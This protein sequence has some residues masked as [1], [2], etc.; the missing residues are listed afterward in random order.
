[1]QMFLRHIQFINV[2]SGVLHQSSGWISGLQN[3]IKSK[4]IIDT[5]Y[6]N[7]AI[8]ISWLNI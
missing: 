2:V 1:M 5:P 4:Y 3:L 6:R 8:I 7:K